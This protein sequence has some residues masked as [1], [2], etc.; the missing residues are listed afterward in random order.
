[1]NISDFENILLNQ[2]AIASLTKKNDKD[3]FNIKKLL[4]NNNLT[5]GQCIKLGTLFQNALRSVAE[6]SGASLERDN[7]IDI[8][9]NNFKH[10][11]S[12]K[13]VDIAFMFKNK[14]YYFEVKTNLQLDSE[15]SKATESKVENIKEYYK[16]KYSLSDE[17][18]IS[19]VLTCWY[20]DEKGLIKTAGSKKIFFA[21]DYLKIFDIDINESEWYDA[22]AKLGKQI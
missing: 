16:N 1:M 19:G 7:L 6:K 3:N 22:F 10:N 12:K 4:K 13:D 20:K 9:S 18:M 15:K 8:N 21:K 17:Q 11:K 2:N 5:Q 14:F